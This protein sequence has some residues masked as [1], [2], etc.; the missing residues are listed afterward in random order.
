MLAQVHSYV[1]QGIDAVACEVEVDVADRGMQK[2]TIVGLPDAG[3]KESMERVR[4]A[5]HNSGYNFPLSR[6]L[7]NLAPAD[8]PK[9]GPLYDL[10]IALGLLLA[11]QTIGTQLHKRLLFA[12]ELALDGRLRPIRGA[13]SMAM[14]AR[15]LKYDGVVVPTDNAS[16]A[17]AAGEVAVYP[18][19]S[20]A[21]VVAFLNQQHHI[22]P[23]DSDA[24]QVL[25]HAR[26][27][28]DFGDIRGQELVKRALTIA[29]AGGHNVLMIGPAGTGKTMSANAHRT[30]RHP[31]DA[32]HQ[33]A[34]SPSAHIYPSTTH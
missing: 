26:P 30:R 32:T 8:L 6:L 22:E 21:T 12:G 31:P 23:A 13:I 17:A 16:E 28:V 11:N 18:A 29:A 4:A 20:L 10:P 14:L 1:L 3:V 34:A 25:A 33:S 27:M 5:I 2:T 24:E 7:V 15:R 9:V 19:D